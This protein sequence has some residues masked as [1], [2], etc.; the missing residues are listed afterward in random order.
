VVTAVA[1]TAC[2][3]PVTGP[4]YWQT[5]PHE[6]V[7][8]VV[9]GTNTSTVYDTMFGR[10]VGNSGQL[11]NTLFQQSCNRKFVGS[12]MVQ[13]WNCTRVLNTGDQVYVFGGH[14]TSLF[15]ELPSLGGKGGALFFTTNGTPPP[16]PNPFFAELLI[17][18]A[19]RG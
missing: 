16:S 4:H 2:G 11:P 19:G 8:T 14:A 6:T 7:K 15:G 3:A 9:T 17:E 5:V 10:L 12:M 18:P 13:D 1:T